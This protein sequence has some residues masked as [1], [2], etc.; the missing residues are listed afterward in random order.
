[1]SKQSQRTDLL[2]AF[3]FFCETTK[4]FISLKKSK[5]SSEPHPSCSVPADF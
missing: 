5:E 2:A 1:M 3:F 4:S